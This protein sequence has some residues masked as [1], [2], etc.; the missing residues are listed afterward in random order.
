V[1]CATALMPELAV[2]DWDFKVDRRVRSY[3]YFTVLMGRIP[4][5]CRCRRA[6]LELELE[7]LVIQAHMSQKPLLWVEADARAV[8]K[9][10][11]CAGVVW[12]CAGV[13]W[14]ACVFVFEALL[15]CLASSDFYG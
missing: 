13:A 2:S 11:E 3:Y 6:R 5:R 7:L 4:V 8:R 14:C 1:L 10:S 9:R 12:A 15:G